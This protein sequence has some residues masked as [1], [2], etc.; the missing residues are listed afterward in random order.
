MFNMNYKSFLATYVCAVPLF[1][2]IFHI[3]YTSVS[4][5]RPFRL[6]VCELFQIEQDLR[7]TPKKGLE[8]KSSNSRY[9][10][11]KAHESAFFYDELKLSVI[12]PFC[13]DAKFSTT[14][15]V[16]IICLL[17]LTCV[18]DYELNMMLRNSFSLN[19]AQ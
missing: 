15:S 2:C 10:R 8:R 3:N 6:K 12:C 7:A 18:F 17:L 9:H 16:V 11:G 1:L 4:F 19:A 14:I 13:A 5:P